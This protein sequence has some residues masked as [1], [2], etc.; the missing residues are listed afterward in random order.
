MLLGAIG[1]HFDLGLEVTKI[2]GTTHVKGA[3]LR[4]NTSNKKRGL[5]GSGISGPGIKAQSFPTPCT[6]RVTR[7]PMTVEDMIFVP[8]GNF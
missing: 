1:G 5:N 2:S 6:V 7:G 4:K 3:S 8:E